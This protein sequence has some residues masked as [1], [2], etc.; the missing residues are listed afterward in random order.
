MDSA[1]FERV[2]MSLLSFIGDSTAADPEAVASYWIQCAPRPVWAAVV[3]SCTSSGASW[4]SFA[5]LS[6]ASLPAMPECALTLWMVIGAF[7]VISLDVIS[8]R[9]DL[10]LC[11]RVDSGLCRDFRISQIAVRLSVNRSRGCSASGIQL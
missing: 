10:C 2:L 3:K 11:V 5:S 6:T 4:A 8:S 7:R 9:I 1:C